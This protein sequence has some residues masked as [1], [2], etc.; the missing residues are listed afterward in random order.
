[1]LEYPTRK[2]ISYLKEHKHKLHS[3]LINFFMYMSANYGF[4]NFLRVAAH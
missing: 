3:S 4:L 2:R 1:M